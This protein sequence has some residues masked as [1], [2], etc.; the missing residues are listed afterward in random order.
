MIGYD[1]ETDRQGAYN[2]EPSQVDVL[3]VICDAIYYSSG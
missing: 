2:L 3:C 1:D